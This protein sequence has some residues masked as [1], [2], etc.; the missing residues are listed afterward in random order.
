MN[1]VTGKPEIIGLNG[2]IV[3]TKGEVA[4]QRVNQADQFVTPYP[5]LIGDNVLLKEEEMDAESI[6]ASGL[7]KGIGGR[8]KL[9]TLVSIG[10]TVKDVPFKEGDY[11]EAF[12]KDYTYFIA[13]DSEKY[14]ICPATQICGYYKKKEV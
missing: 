8:K 13:F 3:S 5:L 2:E 11:V 4:E 6:M 7:I 12:T 9:Y 1:A 10:H 14:I